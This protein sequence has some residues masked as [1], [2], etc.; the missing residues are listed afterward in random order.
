[1][2]ELFPI[3]VGAA[4]GALS[5][6]DLRW[7]RPLWLRLLMIALAGG[8]ATFVS[9]EYQQSWLFVCADILEVAFCALI[10]AF[11][12]NYLRTGRLSLR[13]SVPASR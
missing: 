12:V 1:M 11:A 10:G 3:G 5:T 4:I 9:G 6:F 13:A 2:D 7:F 8:T